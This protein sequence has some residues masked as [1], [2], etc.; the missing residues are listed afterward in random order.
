MSASGPKNSCHL[1][2]AEGGMRADYGMQNE[3]GPHGGQ[4]CFFQNQ[5]GKL[6]VRKFQCVNTYFECFSYYGHYFNKSVYKKTHRGKQMI[7]NPITHS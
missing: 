1:S 6:L 7:Y 2:P 3:V 5:K 4:L